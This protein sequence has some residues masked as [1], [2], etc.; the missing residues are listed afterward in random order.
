M[1]YALSCFNGNTV[2]YRSMGDFIENTMLPIIN[3]K[4]GWN[5][6][7]TKYRVSDNNN[8]ADA[9]A[10]HRDVFFK[11]NN[12]E[13]FPVYTCLIYL[14]P[15]RMQIIPGSHGVV[16][17]SI[18]NAMHIFNNNVE[19]VNIEP[20]DMLVFHSNTLHRGIF[21]DNVKS[22]KLIQVFDVHPTPDDFEKNNDKIMHV[23]GKEKNSNLFIK[24]SKNPL[25]A[26]IIN[27]FGFLNSSMGHGKN[28]NLLSEL[29]YGD[30]H[31]FSSEG[32]RGRLMIDKNEKYQ[33]INKY[34]FN[35]RINSSDNTLDEK[36]HSAYHYDCFDR[37]FI[38]YTILSV[39]IV[40]LLC[41]LLYLLISSLCRDSKRV[42]RLNVRRP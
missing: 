19:E 35:D 41:Y 15:A 39:I 3:K 1:G 25:S 32:L 28:N 17:Y 14:D 30:K 4:M 21:T 42:R 9:S 37:Q 36:H 6:V 31:V 5:S 10:F 38:Q 29:G 13:I 8:S 33:P 24:L 16:K 7:Y 2:D 20:G 22:R 34:V 27:F 12:P 11:T 26:S 40:L 23:L 18:G